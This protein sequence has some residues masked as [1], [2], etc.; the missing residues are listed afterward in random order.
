MVLTNEKVA[1]SPLVDGS[2]TTLHS[3][4]GGGTGDV[5]FNKRAPTGDITVPA[6]YCAVIAGDYEI[7]TG[8]FLEIETNGILEIL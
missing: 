1:A 2:V 8:H 5:S 3:H 6:G 7:A 4:A